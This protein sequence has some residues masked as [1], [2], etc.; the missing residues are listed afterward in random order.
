MWYLKKFP[1]LS[2]QELY[3]IFALRVSVFV[4]EQNC[5][6]QEVDEWDKA[7]IHLFYQEDRIVCYARI[8][9]TATSVRIGRVIVAPAN[10]GQK[11]GRRLLLK[12]IEV[13]QRMS[14]GR[15]IEVS[16]Q[17][18]LEALYT[19]VG[20]IKTSEIYLEDD[21]PHMDMVYDQKGGER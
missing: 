5:A 19:S 1:E 13:A 7:C 10:R 18:H 17:A 21:I 2:T 8:I 6:Y 9:P 16:A 14:D 15:P 3:D 11:W 20:F 4:V 12:A